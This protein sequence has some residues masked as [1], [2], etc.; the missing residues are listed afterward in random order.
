MKLDVDG[1]RSQGWVYLEV[2]IDARENEG[3][4]I[5]LHMLLN[6]ANILKV[7]EY[8][9]ENEYPWITQ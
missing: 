8:E 2:L 7:F 6:M 5:H 3:I 1:T 4:A 9:Q